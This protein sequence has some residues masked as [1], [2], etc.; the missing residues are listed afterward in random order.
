MSSRLAHKAAL[1]TGAASGIGAATAQA[2]ATEGA[3]LI[4]ADLHAIPLAPNTVPDRVVTVKLDVSSEDSWQSA[5]HTAQAVFGGLDVLVNVAGIVSWDG[6]E[7]TTRAD[8]D[9]VIAVN[10]TGMW[11]GMKTAVPQLKRSGAASI[12]NTSSVLGI[13]GG[14]G[15]A[16]YHASKG[17]VRLLYTTAAVQ[18]ATE[19]IR[20][21]SIHP[22]VIAT[23]MIQ[24]ILD[25][26]GDRQADIL[27]T[28]MRRAGTPE[29]I[30]AAMIFLASDESSFITG[31]ELVVDG[32]LTAH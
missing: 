23:A 7:E 21:D 2:F 1:I 32:G 24:D 20:V 18:Y 14:G 26:E 15:A 30:A 17:A 5:V 31:A 8:W 4:L 10:Q 22:G 12:I 9:R 3:R 16:A 11:L 28:P 19:G 6:I 13:I 25:A 27:R 29:E